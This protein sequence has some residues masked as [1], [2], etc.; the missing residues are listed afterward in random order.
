MCLCDSNVNHAQP[1]P[2]GCG[3][4]SNLAA[5]LFWD[6]VKAFSKSVQTQLG[7]HVEL[8]YKQ[9]SIGIAFR[10]AS[11]QFEM[12]IPFVSLLAFCPHGGLIIVMLSVSVCV[13]VAL[14]RERRSQY[15]WRWTAWFLQQESSTW[16]VVCIS[17]LFVFLSCFCGI[18]EDSVNILILWWLLRTEEKIKTLR[19]PYVLILSILEG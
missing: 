11:Q 18:N 8:F 1:S 14:L 5:C 3:A 4:A 6:F 16:Q 10:F 2:R 15:A 7:Q 9:I 13:C 17:R 19:K 12:I